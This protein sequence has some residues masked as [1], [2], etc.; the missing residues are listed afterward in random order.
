MK[1]KPDILTPFLQVVDL[2]HS[3]A[4]AVLKSTKKV[5]LFCLSV[6]LSSSPTPRNHLKDIPMVKAGSV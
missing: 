4:F 1:Q 3:L 6:S 5:Y 2:S